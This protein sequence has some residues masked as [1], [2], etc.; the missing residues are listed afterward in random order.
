MEILK[1]RNFPTQDGIYFAG[2]YN[3]FHNRLEVDSVT[4]VGKECFVAGDTEPFLFTDFDYWSDLWN[5]D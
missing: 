2:N 1:H 3:H 5:F 4:V